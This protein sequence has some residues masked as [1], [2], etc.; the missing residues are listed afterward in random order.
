M[1]TKG[2]ELLLKACLSSILLLLPREQQTIKIEERTAGKGEGREIFFG[3]R[4]ETPPPPKHPLN[5]PS[6]EMRCRI[7][8]EPLVP[9]M[10]VLLIE[11]GKKCSRRG[12]IHNFNFQSQPSSSR[13]GDSFLPSCL[14]DLSSSFSCLDRWF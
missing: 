3:L 6:T 11:P 8:V 14:W 1:G 2:K 12:E 5:H 4:T 9:V 10:G 7:Q 13:V